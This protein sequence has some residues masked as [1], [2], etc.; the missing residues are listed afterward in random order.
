M[1]NVSKRG[2]PNLKVI[3]TKPEKAKEK[4]TYVSWEELVG[5]R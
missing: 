5:S 4:N 1:E 3:K 2:R